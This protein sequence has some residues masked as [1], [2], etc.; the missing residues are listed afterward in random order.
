[1]LSELEFY[2]QYIIFRGF[3]DFRTSLLGF[4]RANVDPSFQVSRYPFGY[5]LTFPV[6]MYDIKRKCLFS[7]LNTK[8]HGIFILATLFFYII[9][10]CLSYLT[11]RLVNPSLESENIFVLM[12]SINGLYN[13]TTLGFAFLGLRML[14]VVRQ[15]NFIAFWGISRAYEHT[16]Q[17]WDDGI[18]L[19]RAVKCCR[20]ILKTTITKLNLMLRSLNSQIMFSHER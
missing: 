16:I 10:G 2:R 15:A 6:S 9:S 1:V 11:K 17:R 14:R 8:T 12:P 18:Q 7:T 13:V 20:C 4:L 5:I 3:A 19:R